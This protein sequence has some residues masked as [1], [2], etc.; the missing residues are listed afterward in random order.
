[1]KILVDIVEE[2]GGREKRMIR[3]D[4]ER[5]IIGNEEDLKGVKEEILK[6]LGEIIKIGIV[7]EI[8][9]MRKKEGK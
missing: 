5:K 8:G 2:E 9:E 7:V 4:E 3:E 6:S 1:M